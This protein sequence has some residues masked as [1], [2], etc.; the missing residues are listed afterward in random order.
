ME[1]KQVSKIDFEQVSF[2]II[3]SA[4]TAKSA[5]MEALYFAKEQKYDEAQEKMDE[6]NKEIADAAH[7]H[8]DVIVEEAQGIDH[9]FKVL[10]MHAED[11]LLTS[12]TL[13]LL[14]GE[15]IEMYKKF[16]K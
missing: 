13:I 14:V 2:R 4:G 3:T 6:A 16:D 15:M 9:K 8:M 5:A 12:Q 1:E 10:F 7:A 11:Q